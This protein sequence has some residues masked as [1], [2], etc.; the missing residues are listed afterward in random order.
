MVTVAQTIKYLNVDAL[1][2]MRFAALLPTHMQYSTAALISLTLSLFSLTRRHTQIQH[3]NRMS[4]SSPSQHRRGLFSPIALCNHLLHSRYCQRASESKLIPPELFTEGITEEDSREI[5]F[6]LKA[7]AYEHWVEGVQVN[8]T[9]E[10]VIRRLSV[11][12]IWWFTP[13]IFLRVWWVDAEATCIQKTAASLSGTLWSHLAF[14]LTRKKETSN[15]AFKLQ[16]SV[17]ARTIWNALWLWYR[18]SPEWKKLICEMKAKRFVHLSA[19]ASSQCQ[20]EEPLLIQFYLDLKVTKPPWLPNNLGRMGSCLNHWFSHRENSPITKHADQTQNNK[21]L[22]EWHH[23]DCNACRPQPS[24][25][26]A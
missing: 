24:Q 18:A 17:L 8:M 4:W 21:A 6:P 15:P 9:F 22:V 5:I 10:I 11:F 19:C 2:R 23:N 3:K 12:L 26:S 25:S 14:F 13:G 1:R 16:I 20:S 7:F